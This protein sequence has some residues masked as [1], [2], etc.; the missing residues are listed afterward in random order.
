MG[1]LN[2]RHFFKDN[3]FKISSIDS[4]TAVSLNIASFSRSIFIYKK[5]Y[6]NL[7][8]EELIEV[9]KESIELAI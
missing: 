3:L 1:R 5:S 8:F 4:M 2:C 9:M 7:N 6:S